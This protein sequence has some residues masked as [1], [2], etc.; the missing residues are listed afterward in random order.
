MAAASDLTIVQ[1]YDAL[2]PRRQWVTMKNGGGVLETSLS[3]RIK[4]SSD[5]YE[6]NDFGKFQG[7]FSRWS[8]L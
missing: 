5:L 1:K 2:Q 8:F 3:K 4:G 7:V 6:S